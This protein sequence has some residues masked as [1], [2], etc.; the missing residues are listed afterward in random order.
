MQLLLAERKAHSGVVAWGTAFVELPST[1]RAALAE[2]GA[3]TL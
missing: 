3:G 1:A 2:I